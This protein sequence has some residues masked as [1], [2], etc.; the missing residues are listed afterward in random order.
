[1]KWTDA[2]RKCTGITGGDTGT[3]E[4]PEYR[5]DSIVACRHSGQRFLQRIEDKDERSTSA[6]IEALKPKQKDDVK[7]TGGRHQPLY[8]EHAGVI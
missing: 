8:K 5:H 2:K 4:K 6:L 7:G 1:M 3:R